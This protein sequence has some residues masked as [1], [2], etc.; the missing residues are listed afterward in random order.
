[1]VDE[2]RSG[3][4]AAKPWEDRGGRT[5]G[6]IVAT[7]LAAGVVAFLLRRSREQEEDI[8]SRVPQMEAGREFLMERVL[9]EMKP[10]LLS[11][12]SELEDLAEQG[13]RSAEKAIKNL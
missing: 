13:F 7:A 9:P 10:V 12:L 4:F 5:V 1:M 11:V 2:G 8:T 6:T 3:G